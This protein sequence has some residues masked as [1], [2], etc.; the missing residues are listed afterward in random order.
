MKVSSENQTRM[1]IDVY[2]SQNPSALSAN[3]G[4]AMWLL[5]LSLSGLANADQPTLPDCTHEICPSTKYDDDAPTPLVCEESLGLLEPEYFRK[6][7]RWQKRYGRDNLDLSLHFLEEVFESQLEPR[8][9]EALESCPAVV[10][11]V[12]MNSVLL[13]ETRDGLRAAK[14]FL[15][16]I[17]RYRDQLFEQL[18]D[19]IRRR[20]LEQLMLEW[21]ADIAYVY[22]KL[23]D[24]QRLGPRPELSQPGVQEEKFC[25]NQRFYVYELDAAFYGPGTF[26]CLQGQWGTEVLL[27]HYFRHNCNTP[28]ADQAA[29]FYVP[30]YA[31]CI[32]VR[33]NANI[34]AFEDQQVIMDMDSVSTKHIFDPLM[35][36]LK[37]SKHFHRR[38]GSDHIFLFAD[39]QG[40]RIWD[41]YDMLR[42]ES[43]F[44]SPES[45]CP[46][47]SEPLRR[48][49]DVK[50]CLSGW[51]DI[52]IPGHTDYARIQYMKSRNRRTA[53]RRLLLTFHGRAPG[54]HDAYEECRVR[55]AGCP[56]R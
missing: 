32:Y 39:G 24:V 21:N 15:L 3:V 44:I 52:V 36:F 23:L 6:F 11:E 34:T 56:S 12:M 20:Q 28:D 43:V 25:L 46:T 22:P 51:K 42:S 1:R 50:R 31:T 27:H 38:E 10:L 14:R 26:G 13:V 16:Q 19:D 40:P 2:L 54:A 17:F 53:D 37:A 49:T 9:Q 45:R 33:L 48:Y 8:I 18:P 4:F 55:G 41:S 35:E 47:W 29:W 7:G 5:V 30:L